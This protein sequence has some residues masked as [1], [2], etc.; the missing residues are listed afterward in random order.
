LVLPLPAL[1]PGLE[2]AVGDHVHRLVQVE[3]LPLRRARRPVL[4]LVLAQRARRI[5]LRRLSLRAEAAARDGARRV[6]LDMGDLAVLHVHELAA[7]DR[8]ERTDRRDDALR[9]ADPR[10]QVLR[11]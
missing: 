9:V 4:H 5:A 6:A 3:L 2:D 1:L 8:A 11:P 7:A 10:A